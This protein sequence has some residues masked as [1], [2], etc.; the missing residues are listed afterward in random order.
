VGSA[1][2]LGQPVIASWTLTAPHDLDPLHVFALGAGRHRFR[3]FW[4]Q[5]AADSTF[6]G[7]GAALAIQTD[8]A[9]RFRDASALAEQARA[10]AIVDGDVLDGAVSGPVFLGG[11]AFDPARPAEPHWRQFPAGLLILP[12]VLWARRDGVATV[13]ISAQLRPDDD[14]ET[15][16]ALA[17]RD[18][19]VLD[20]STAGLP[21]FRSAHRAVEWTERPPS[22]DWKAAVAAAAADVRAGRFEKVVLAREVRVCA[23]APLRPEEVLDR[24]R[25]A[26]PRAMVFA[27]GVG[28]QCFL[29]ATPE[30]LVRLSQRTVT[31]HCLAGSIARGASEDEAAELAQ[32]LLASA[33]DRVEHE[34]VAQSTEAALRAVCD[35]VVRAPETPY[36]V[37][38]G[39]VQHLLTPLTGRVR[40]GKGLLELVDVLHPTPAVGGFPR[41]VAMEAIREREGL[42][43][44]W[45]AGPVGWMDFA[46][47]GEF[48]V[49]IRS[50]LLTGAEAFLYA[51][52][53]IV[54]DSEPEAEYQETCLKLKPMLAALNLQ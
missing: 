37:R 19:D 22:V 2:R 29:G 45:Y 12:R 38:S 51:G 28:D 54:A 31:A 49:A 7:L 39:S 15:A 21:D 14:P 17:L 3:I 18:L 41:E 33:K 24:L 42:D 11:F 25:L 23:S 53:G 35:E 44:G 34:I 9:T 4:E 10:T 8:G 47:D 40:N 26:N 13:T 32:R 27:F 50:A 52:C 43:R 5:A 46:G 1:R 6:A 48:G 30:L 16:A 36:V 20:A